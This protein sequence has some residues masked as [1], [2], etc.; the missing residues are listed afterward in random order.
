MSSDI[1][2][3]LIFVLHLHLHYSAVCNTASTLLTSCS[4]FTLSYSYLFLF[5]YFTLCLFLPVFFI[6]QK[7]I[8]LALRGQCFWI[9]CLGSVVAGCLCFC[10]VRVL[11]CTLV[12]CER[13]LNKF[14]IWILFLC[15]L[16]SKAET[17]IYFLRWLR[18]HLFTWELFYG[19]LVVGQQTLL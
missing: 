7:N 19:H 12:F 11:F 16:F 1:A 6:S 18:G 17:L 14:I 13:L 3:L 10:Q 15:Y 8:F 4:K 2:S 5:D 9:N